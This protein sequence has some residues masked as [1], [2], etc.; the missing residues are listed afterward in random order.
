M[1]KF[2]SLEEGDRGSLWIVSALHGTA[3]AACYQKGGSWYAS[4]DGSGSDEIGPFEDLDSLIEHVEEQR[5]FGPWG[6]L[7]N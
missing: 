2:L 1:A 4:E 5:L 7:G 6:S 3:V